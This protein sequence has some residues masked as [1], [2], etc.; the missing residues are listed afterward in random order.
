MATWNLDNAHS[1]IE[2]KVKHMMISTVKGQ[3]QE[4]S[5]TV[6]SESENL[7]N[8]KIAVE[9]QTASV[10]T[11][12]EQ[13]DQHLKSEDF[14]NV[15]SFPIIKFQSTGID[16]E[17]A[18]E[19]KLTGDLTIKDITKSVTFDVEFG[20]LAKDPWGNQKA[21]Y[22]VTGKINRTDFGLTWNAA[23]ETGGVMVSEE[24]KFQADIQFALS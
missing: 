14:F 5:V 2:F 13:R 20:G 4:F 16:Q 8:A 15:S 17:S 10:T 12:N 11:K 6:D 22:T 19:F 24:V 18:G 9:I 21:G 3:F 1:E 23:L 7:D